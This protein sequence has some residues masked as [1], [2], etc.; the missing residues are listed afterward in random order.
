MV[1]PTLSHQRISCDSKYSL[2]PLA[3][4]RKIAAILSTWDEAITLTG[5][6]IAALQRRK[7]ALM[8]LLLTGAVR[9]PE[10]EDEWEEA[11]L[12]K[13]VQIEAEDSTETEYALISDSSVTFI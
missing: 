6:L 4:Q 9:F 3:E 7:Q 8:Q 13:Y 1:T 12:G 5:Q 10:F 11:K 2:P